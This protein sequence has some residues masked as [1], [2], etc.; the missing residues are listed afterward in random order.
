MNRENDNFEIACKFVIRLGTLVHRYGAQ[1]ARIE[2]YLVRV[3]RALG[4]DGVFRSTPT[5]ILFTFLRNMSYG[6]EHI[7]FICQEQAST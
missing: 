3:I 7:L 5:G 4:F 1:T 2:S 6:I